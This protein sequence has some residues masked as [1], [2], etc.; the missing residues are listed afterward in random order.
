MILSLTFPNISRKDLLLLELTDNIQSVDKCA[1]FGAEVKSYLRALRDLHVVALW[2]GAS[3]YYICEWDGWIT[4]NITYIKYL[5][6]YSK[7]TNL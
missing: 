3:C 5:F 7:I 6:Y 1:R 2:F 4:N